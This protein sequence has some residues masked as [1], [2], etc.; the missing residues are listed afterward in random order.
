M[1]LPTER[2]TETLN[3]KELKVIQSFF[4]F[5]KFYKN[6]KGIE[7]NI[8]GELK[9]YTQ[10][11]KGNVLGGLTAGVVALPLC[12]AFGIASGLGAAAGLYGAICLSFFAA[13]FGGTKTQISGPTGPMTVVTAAV[14]VALNGNLAMVGSV[15]LVAGLFQIVFGLLRLGKFV[16]YIPYSVVS[17]FMCGVGVIIILL[18]LSPLLGGPN[19]KGPVDGILILGSFTINWQSFILGAIALAM[20]YLTPKKIDAIFPAP[21]M[22]LI[23]LTCVAYFFHMDVAMIGE[24]PSGLPSIK[25]PQVDFAQIKTIVSYGLMLALLGCIDSLLTSLVADSMTKT[26]HDSNRECIG[27]G[28]GNALCGFV[29]GCVGAGATMRT[30]TNIKVGGTG[31]LSGV[32]ASL[33]LLMVLI[34]LHGVVCY[35]PLSVLAGIL[36]SVGV[37]ILDYRLIKEIKRCPKVDI[38]IF[39]AVFLLTVFWDLI[40]AVG[41]GIV[42]ATVT[43][44]YR[45]NCDTY[46]KVEE[47]S[48]ALICTIRGGFYYGASSDLASQFAALNAKKYILD[49]SHC[50]FA[51]VSGVYA[52]EDEIAIKR[53]A[54]AEVY[55]VSK[56]TQQ[57]MHMRE[58][59]GEGFSFATRLEALAAVEKS[60]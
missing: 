59:M 39:V 1:R 41:I 49:L 31:R 32:I 8:A 7:V 45:L 13:I 2:F 42:L 50:S 53:T 12:L 19:P 46:M 60:H 34:N 38:A 6:N 26:K 14:I 4:S 36:V 20:I 23:L 21:L 58:K 22:A 33:F 52:F 28:I 55:L 48:G 29:C 11:I 37:N 40:C 54:G 25:L 17:G 47:K 57:L 18:Q 44:V 24:V 15:F 9:E 5:L 10:N 16:K 51:D 3:P 30:V 43:L 27:Q 56:P 35:V